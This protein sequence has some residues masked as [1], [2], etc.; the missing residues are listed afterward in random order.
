MYAIVAKDQS[1]S[2]RRVSATLLVL[3]LVVSAMSI[4]APV[5]SVGAQP[6]QN[7]TCEAL[8]L[9]AIDVAG[10]EFSQGRCLPD[11]STAGNTFRTTGG[12]SRENPTLHSELTQFPPDAVPGLQMEGWFPDSCDRYEAEAAVAFMPTCPGGMRHNGQFVLRIPDSWDGVHLVVAG[13]PGIRD[14]YA[15]DTIVSDWVLDRGWAYIGHDRGNTGLNF[16]RAG[17]DE[18]GG[19]LLRWFPPLAMTQWAGFIP[20]SVSGRRQRP[21]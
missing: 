20:L 8:D 7:R 3:A 14:Q 13:A 11:L 17:D 12:G 2:R 19:D 21:G 16:F 9:E 15:Q 1:R 4:G 5:P 10:A 6:S 18:T